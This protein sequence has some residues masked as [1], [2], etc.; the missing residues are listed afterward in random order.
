MYYIVGADNQPRGPVDAATLNQWIAEG[1]ANGQTQARTET[2]QSWQPLA[3]FPEFAP[4]LTGVASPPPSGYPGAGP[5]Q[6]VQSPTE[7]DATGGLIPYKNKHALI[8]YYM[9]F[10]GLLI[11]CIPLIG[12]LY[13]IA[14]IWLGVQGLK[15][16][17]ANPVVKGT[18]HAWIAIIGGGVELIGGII[19]TVWFIGTILSEGRF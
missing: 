17:K 13:S 11:M 6:M 5:P 14:T 2:G 8:G 15:S 12:F 9:A 18:A 19:S 16:V 7:G 1:R 10:G 3:Y 4:A